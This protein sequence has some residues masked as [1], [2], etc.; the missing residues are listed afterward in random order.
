MNLAGVVLCGGRSSRM[1]LAKAS[2]PFGTETLLVRVVRIVSQVVKPVIVVAAEEQPMPEFSRQVTV[3]RDRDPQRGPLEGLRAGLEGLGSVCDTAF[4]TGC[5]TPLLTSAFIERM[6]ALLG[7]HQIAVPWID[8]FDHPL[9]AVYRTSVLPHV[10]ALLAADRLRPAYLF[11]QVPTRRVTAEELRDVD[12]GLA[13]L[14][15]L[16]APADYLATLAEEGLE[17]PTEIL[18]AFESRPAH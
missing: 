5:D 9:A 10:E 17:A 7:E 3:V 11:E 18:R 13:C 8:G 4:V 12:P 6:A 1:G 16:N 2:L 15:N 14:R